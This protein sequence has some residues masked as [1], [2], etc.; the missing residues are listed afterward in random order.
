LSKILVV[1]ELKW[2]TKKKDA[3]VDTLLTVKVFEMQHNLNF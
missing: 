2:N 3:F 1:T